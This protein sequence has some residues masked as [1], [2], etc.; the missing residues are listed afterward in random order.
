MRRAY[1][2]KRSGIIRRRDQNFFME[3]IMHCAKLLQVGK[4][5]RKNLLGKTQ[6]HFNSINEKYCLND[7]FRRKRMMLFFHRSSF[8]S[9]AAGPSLVSMADIFGRQR[10][11]RRTSAPCCARR[12]L[13]PSRTRFDRFGNQKAASGDSS[14]VWSRGVFGPRKRSSISNSTPH[15]WQLLQAA[16]RRL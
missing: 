3:D 10:C 1:L 6:I 15:I 7:H 13:R 12:V 2:P 4:K 8:F 5:F 9:S 11:T 16:S 14:L